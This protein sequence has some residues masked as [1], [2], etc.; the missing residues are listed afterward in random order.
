MI[1]I[2]AHNVVKHWMEKRDHLKSMNSFLWHRRNQFHASSLPAESSTSSPAVQS[3]AGEEII[4]VEVDVSQ[5]M[6][7]GKEDREYHTRSEFVTQKAGV[8][9]KQED[10]YHCYMCKWLAVNENNGFSDSK[11]LQIMD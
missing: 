1:L 4:K 2:P 11:S 6:A 3:N 7:C 10:E 9:V 5:A 8:F